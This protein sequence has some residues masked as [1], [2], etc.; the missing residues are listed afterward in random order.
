MKIYKNTT[1]ILQVTSN[2]R[3]DGVGCN[4]DRMFN[5]EHGMELSNDAMHI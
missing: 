3:Q 2:T 4:N 5:V 1:L